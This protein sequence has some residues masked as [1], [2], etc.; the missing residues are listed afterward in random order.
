MFA[1][2]ITKRE[3]L[4]IIVLA[5]KEGISD[6][7]GSW[8]TPFVSLFSLDHWDLQILQECMKSKPITSCHENL[9]E[10]IQAELGF[11]FFF[12]DKEYLIIQ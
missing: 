10:Y 12:L 6:V 1:L 3:P 5:A 7:I 11:F 2:Q 4:L 8:L 9:H